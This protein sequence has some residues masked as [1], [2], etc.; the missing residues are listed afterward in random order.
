MIPQLQSTDKVFDV[1]V[2]QGPADSS[3]AVGEETVELPQLQ[4][5]GTW[6]LVVPRQMPG[7]SDVRKL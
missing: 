1:S 5:V 3:G 4:L 2:V 7:R 6:T